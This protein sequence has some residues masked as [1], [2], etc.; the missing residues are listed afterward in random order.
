M[1]ILHKQRTTFERV[2]TKNWRKDPKSNF[3]S[4]GGDTWISDYLQIPKS[5]QQ[6]VLSHDVLN[7]RQMVDVAKIRNLLKRPFSSFVFV[8]VHS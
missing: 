3:W 6:D 4:V 5:K 1:L 8:A 2:G 7:G